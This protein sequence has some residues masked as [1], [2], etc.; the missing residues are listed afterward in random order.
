MYKRAPIKIIMTIR[1]AIFVF[2]MRKETKVPKNPTIMNGPPIAEAMVF[3]IPRF[4][5]FI[6]LA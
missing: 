2:P 5:E 1:R 6:K 3:G 4:D